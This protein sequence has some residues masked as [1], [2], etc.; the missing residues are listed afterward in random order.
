MVLVGASISAKGL[1][2]V[3]SITRFRVS[4]KVMIRLRA[5]TAA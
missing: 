1:V 2:G 3:R 5:R 4:A